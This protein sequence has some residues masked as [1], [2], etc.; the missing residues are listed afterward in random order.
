[1]TKWLATLA[2]FGCFLTFADA[3][4]QNYPSRGITII[5]TSAAGAATDVLTRAV[6]QRLSQRWGQPVVVEN[7]GGAGHNLAGVAVA[8]AD[9]DGYT[10]LSTEIGFVTIQPHLY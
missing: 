9:R 3:R 5:V 2:A 6:A 8:K 4:A 1:M 10:L 7:R